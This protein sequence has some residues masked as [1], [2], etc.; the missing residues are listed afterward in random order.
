MADD[1]VES[2]DG[3]ARRHPSPMCDP[4]SDVSAAPTDAPAAEFLTPTELSRDS[5]PK[6][7]VCDAERKKYLATRNGGG[8]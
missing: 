4:T 3:H 2:V 1:V 6:R 7:W 8:E 5:M